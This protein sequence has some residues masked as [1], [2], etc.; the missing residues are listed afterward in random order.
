[1]LGRGGFGEVY[2]G[3]DAKL[4]RWVAVKL[5]HQPNPRA[6]QRFL[7]EIEAGARL[8]HPGIVTVHDAGQEGDQVFLVMEFVQGHNL[9]ELCQTSLHA[10]RAAE[11]VLQIA[12]AV[13]HA[14]AK[15]IWHRDLKPENVI[16][17]TAGNARVLDFG[18]AFLANDDSQRLS[19]SGLP[20]GTPG[21]MPPEQVGG[22]PTEQS[23]VW[24]LGALLYFTL[25]GGGPFDDAPQ[26]MAAA[27]QRPPTPPRQL[28][29][30][31]PP[32]LEAIC[33]RCLKTEPRD[34]YP[35][36]RAVSAA[37]AGFLRGDRPANTAS[38]RLP[39][40]LAVGLTV[41]VAAGA[42]AALKA[43]TDPD[44]AVA[45]PT[46]A[47]PPGPSGTTPS[48]SPEPPASPPPTVDELLGQLRRESRRMERYAPLADLL[49]R[50][51]DVAA[52]DA[53][54]ERV[55]L[56]WSA[57]DLR[58]GRLEEGLQRILRRDWFHEQQRAARLEAELR[59]QSDPSDREVLRACEMMLDAPSGPVR[60]MALGLKAFLGR[61]VFRALELIR[62]AAEA[63]GDD[64]G[65]HMLLGRALLTMGD[66]Q[67][68]R[69]AAERAIALCPDD[70][71]PYTIL[72]DLYLNTGKFRASVEASD[73]VLE[74]VED[75]ALA[76]QYVLRAKAL[77]GAGQDREAKADL[78]HA[79]EIEPESPY[80]YLDRCLLFM[81]QGDTERARLDLRAAI[82]RDEQAVRE[83]LATLHPK[84]RQRLQELL[85]R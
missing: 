6:R 1:V 44:A 80:P 45:S 19:K 47:V 17:D 67:G 14:H 85:D 15:G 21:F 27:T 12:D 83:A 57:L 41:A 4:A 22:R 70:Y 64:H 20:L 11:I 3:W 30:Q 23:D 25:T 79:M 82:D 76:V 72:R 62:K 13:A 65:P 68:A 37:L 55:L 42:A 73:H 50:A 5:L 39:A 43:P 8:R 66:P 53:E 63:A 32:A 33:L 36:A 54:R 38:W 18:L 60:D 31:I 34:R 75:H 49:A 24:G 35:S 52:D 16:V 48:P 69:S 28:S 59:F 9:S 10:G 77:R 81:S 26:P 74:L 61:D 51:L 56:A 29:P 2:R 7:R 46:P 84:A 71:R 78:E 40:A 58:R